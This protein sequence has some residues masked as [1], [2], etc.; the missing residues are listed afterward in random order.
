[1]VWKKLK[2]SRDKKWNFFLAVLCL[3]SYLKFFFFHSLVI[4]SIITTIQIGVDLWL[5]SLFWNSFLHKILDSF[6]LGLRVTSG[7][8]VWF[9]TEK[10][11]TVSHQIGKEEKFYPNRYRNCIWQYSITFTITT[12]KR[13]GIEEKFL[14]IIKNIYKMFTDNLISSERHIAFSKDQGQST[15]VLSQHSC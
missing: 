11:I 14:N 8:Q 6:C 15:G 3:S 1:M 13:E 5:L 2:I 4:L 9:N 12:D 7:K 10:L